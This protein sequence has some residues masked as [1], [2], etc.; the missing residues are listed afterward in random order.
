LLRKTDLPIAEIASLAG[1]NDSNYFTRQFK[2]ING[3]SPRTYRK[4]I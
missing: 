3:K 4:I 1:F 2:K